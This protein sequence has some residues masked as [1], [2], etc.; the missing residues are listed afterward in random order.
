M[1]DDPH[2]STHQV[3][4]PPDSIGFQI[5][6]AAQIHT[7]GLLV[8]TPHC[9]TPTDAPSISR[10]S[11]ALFMEPNW[12]ERMDPPKGCGVDDVVRYCVSEK[13]PKLGERWR[14]GM[15]FGEFLK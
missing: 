1:E 8:A 10:E 2:P 11:Y 5:G 14:E 4:L 6:E 7:G 12:D 15:T 13:V 9:V 3:K